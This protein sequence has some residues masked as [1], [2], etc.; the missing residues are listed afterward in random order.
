MT[1][2]QLQ[3]QVSAGIRRTLIDII[4]TKN[5]CYHKISDTWLDQKP[6]DMLLIHQ[7]N[8]WIIELKIHNKWARFNFN[9]VK[10]HQYTAMRSADKS[11]NRWVLMIWYWEWRGRRIAIFDIKTFDKIIEKYWKSLPI[12]EFE[13]EADEIIKKNL[14]SAI[15][16]NIW[17]FKKMLTT[18]YEWL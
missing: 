1:E 4:K 10:P 3:T 2:A 15:G 18:Y 8:G 13:N 12:S 5:F 9:M 17:N 14:K 6:S 16:E 11:W 7:N